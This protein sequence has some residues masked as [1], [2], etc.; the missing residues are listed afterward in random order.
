MAEE[1]ISSVEFIYCACGCGLTRPKFDNQGRE[2]RFIKGHKSENHKKN[3]GNA[4]LGEKNHGWKG[5]NITYKSLHKWIR[6]NF[7]KPDLCQLCK[8][9]PPREIACITGIYDRE[10]KNWAWFCIPCHRKWDNIIPRVI[11][12]RQKKISK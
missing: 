12:N 8:Q 5:N 4:Q 11:I 6:R 2:H 9:I 1:S 7:P 3:I 10:L